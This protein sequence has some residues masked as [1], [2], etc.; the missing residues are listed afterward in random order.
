MHNMITDITYRP[1]VREDVSL[2]A[3]LHTRSWQVA[4]RGMLPDEY[5]DDHCPRERLAVWTG[6]LSSPPSN[7]YALIA[8][9]GRVPIGFACVYLDDSSSH[10]TLLDNIHVLPAYQEQ[11][12]GRALMHQTALYASDH[13]KTSGYYLWVLATNEKALHFYEGLGGQVGEIINYPM[14]H[15]DQRDITVDCQRVSWDTSDLIRLS[16][17]RSQ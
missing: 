4:Y 13:A 12:I 7:Q 17:G 10:G 5:L 16:E 15:Y 9:R 14:I 1:A 6:R 3:D 2:I 8:E 11:G